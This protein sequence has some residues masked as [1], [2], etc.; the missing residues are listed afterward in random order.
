MDARLQ[1]TANVT[2]EKRNAHTGKVREVIRRHNLV[3]NAGLNQ[4][5][6]ALAGDSVTFPTHLAVGTGT[7]DETAA[8]TTLGTEVF[9]DT[10]TSKAKT[11][12]GKTTYKYFLASGS[13]NGN[14]ISEAG[15][16][17]A[18]SAGTMFARA[19]FPADVKTSAEAWTFSWTI[20]VEVA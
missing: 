20:T 7:T 19:T 14:D 10:L 1:I 15:L 3:V 4:L 2:I 12:T 5:R 18:A 11:A 17:N 8:D 13:A 16:F 9:R 6:D